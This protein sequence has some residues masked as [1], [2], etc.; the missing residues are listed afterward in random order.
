MH[1]SA[2]IVFDNPEGSAYEVRINDITGKLVYSEANVTMD[3]IEINRNHLPGGY[4]FIQ[5][6]GNKLY[7]GVMVIE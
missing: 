7:R 3:R 4:Y 5:L 1:L 2:I 6:K